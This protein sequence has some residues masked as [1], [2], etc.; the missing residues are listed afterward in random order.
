TLVPYVADEEGYDYFETLASNR[1]LL[2][3]RPGGDGLVRTWVGLE[4]LM[5]CT[6][7]CFEEAAAMAAE[8]GTGIHTH[9]SESM[10]EVSE[11]LRRW[12]RRP[13]EVMY[14]RGLL[15]PHTL[16]A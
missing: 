8:F 4:H 11:S 15:G 7:G 3:S 13:I 14:D 10:W 6:A 1:A 12:G 9:S 5:Y 16:I 2:E